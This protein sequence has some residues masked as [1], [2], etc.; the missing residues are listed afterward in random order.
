[1]NFNLATLTQGLALGMVL[2]LGGTAAIASPSSSK[3]VTL[4][5]LSD[6][7]GKMVPHQELFEISGAQNY[8]GG[9]TKMATAIKQVRA[10]SPNALLLMLGDTTHGSAETLFTMGESVMNGINSLGID[11]FTPGNWDFGHGPRAFRNRFAGGN[12]AGQLL[13]LPPNNRTTLS[14]TKPAG[15]CPG[16]PGVGPGTGQF[17]CNVTAATFDTVAINLYNYN[18]ALKKWVAWYC[19]RTRCWKAMVS[20]LLLSVLLPM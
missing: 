14:S 2:S 7:H 16:L 3:T 9:L 6:L 10:D 1:M 17:T 4:M 15:A 11:V 18:E 20:R 13:P 5:Q 19:L 12:P 8:S